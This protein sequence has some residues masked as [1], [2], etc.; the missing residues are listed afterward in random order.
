MFDWFDPK[1]FATVFTTLFLAELGDKTQLATI[2]LTAS[3]RKPVSVFLGAALALATV[4]LVGVLFGS[5]L[6]RVI[7]E[8]WIRRAAALLFVGIGLWMLLAPASP[9]N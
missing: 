1:T 7:P 2:T 8:I 3:T 6:L 5:A 9:G 4:T